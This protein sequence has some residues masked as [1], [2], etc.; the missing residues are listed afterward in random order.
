VYCPPFAVTILELYFGLN[1][2]DYF[3]VKEGEGLRQ[4]P[5]VS[6]SRQVDLFNFNISIKDYNKVSGDYSSYDRTIPS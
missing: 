2:V 1:I 6:G 4:L 3:K 5:I